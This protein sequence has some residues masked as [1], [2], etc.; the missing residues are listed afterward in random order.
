MPLA[1]KWIISHRCANSRGYYKYGESIFHLSPT[2]SEPNKNIHNF[3][4]LHLRISH[5][6]F[7]KRALNQKDSLFSFIIR[8]VWWMHSEIPNIGKSNATKL[9]VSLLL[10]AYNIACIT[11][12]NG[13]R[14]IIFKLNRLDWDM[15]FDQFQL[16]SSILYYMYAYSD[17]TD[18]KCYEWYAYR[19]RVV[20]HDAL[21]LLSIWKF[22]ENT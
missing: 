3:V 22:I 15:E 4:P 16:L 5:S 12:D 7:N 19:A 9:N 18:H 2:I 6:T 14:R 8:N 17:R 20:N 1:A 21:N 13:I 10:L 11:L